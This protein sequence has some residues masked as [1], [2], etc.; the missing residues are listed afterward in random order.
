[1]TGIGARLGREPIGIDPAALDLLTAYD[2][3]GNVRELQ[4]E[5][6]RAV[7][8]LGTGTR[9]RRE[10][11]SAKIAG[12]GPAPQQPPPAGGAQPGATSQSTPPVTQAAPSPVMPAESE[13]V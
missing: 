3:P 8:L 4:N 12:G 10:H 1:L 9:I 11:L 2:W 7:A 6:E 5:I 13:H